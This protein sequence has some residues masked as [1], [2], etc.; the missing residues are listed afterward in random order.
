M[1]VLRK[2]SIRSLRILAFDTSTQMINLCLM[3]SGQVVVGREIP[4]TAANRQE[5]VTMLVPS[6]DAALKEAGWEKQ[7]LTC[8]VVGQG[9]GSFTGIRTAVVTAKT[10]AQALK[11][12]L[13]GASSLECYAHQA[14][15]PVA[16]LLSG[17]PGYFFAAAYSA[18]GDLQ[19]PPAYL[20]CDAAV[21]TFKPFPRWLA[22]DAVRQQLEPAAS[23]C[24]PLPVLKNI[25]VIQAQIVQDRLSLR[26]RDR[27]SGEE[28]AKLAEEFSWR[29]VEPLYL[30]SP[31]VTVKKSDA[32]Q[33]Q[34][35]DIR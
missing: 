20:S 26:V 23:H 33:D 34:A 31:S 24:E 11:L 25:A 35:D 28:R 1:T 12:P 29:H 14:H 2:R 8:L 15:S 3:D 30:R 5:A 27:L 17:A 21:E 13:L 22:D 18:G 6:I 4:P 19:V 32:N 9:P 10:L 7:S 16:V